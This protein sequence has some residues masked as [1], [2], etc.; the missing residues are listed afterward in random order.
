M[1]LALSGCGIFAPKDLYG[2][3]DTEDVDS[4][5]V[6]RDG[7]G[8]G[9]SEDCD[10]QDAAVHPDAEETPGDGVDSNCD[11]DDDT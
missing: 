3:P 2:G 10:D 6:D 7:D 11:G 1:G 5:F 8:F 9:V 4:P